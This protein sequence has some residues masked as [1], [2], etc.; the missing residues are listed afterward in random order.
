MYT[1]EYIVIKSVE[2]DFVKTINTNLSYCCFLPDDGPESGET[3]RK[4]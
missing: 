3:N 4:L 2:T 1:F